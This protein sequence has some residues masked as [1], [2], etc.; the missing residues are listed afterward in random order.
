MRL[1]ECVCVRVCVCV[2][3]RETDTDTDRETDRQRHRQTDRDK[4]RE[5][6][7]ERHTERDRDRQTDRQSV[8]LCTPDDRAVYVVG[9]WLQKEGPAPGNY[10]YVPPNAGHTVSSSFKSKTPRFSTSHTVRPHSHLQLA[11]G[12]SV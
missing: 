7:R 10:N 6:Q 8:C 4:E 5:T 9:L 1:T 3:E 11:H 2:R 12:T